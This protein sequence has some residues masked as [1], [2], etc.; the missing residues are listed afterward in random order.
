MPA[1]APAAP[2]KPAMGVQPVIPPDQPVYSL[3]GRLQAQAAALSESHSHPL[4]A[5]P[6]V[7]AVTAAPP[8]ANTDATLV[9]DGR[10]ANLASA[11]AQDVFK[12]SGAQPAERAQPD[13]QRDS[14][15][16]N[17]AGGPRQTEADLHQ[18]PALLASTPREDHKATGAASNRVAEDSRH[19]SVTASGSRLAVEQQQPPRRRRQFHD[20]PAPSGLAPGRKRS[21]S[22]DLELGRGTKRSRHAWHPTPAAHARHAEHRIP[23]QGAP[24]YDA[25]RG[26]TTLSAKQDTDREMAWSHRSSHS[27]SPTP[28]SV[29]RESGPFTAR[30][31]SMAAANGRHVAAGSRSMSISPA[32]A[33]S[34]NSVPRQPHGAA[35]GGP[36]AR[37][38]DP[39]MLHRSRDNAQHPRVAQPPGFNRQQDHR[40][41]SW[42]H[43]EYREGSLPQRESNHHRNRDR[44]FDGHSN[45]TDRAA[46]GRS[47]SSFANMCH[48]SFQSPT[49][50]Q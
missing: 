23:S 2:L 37:N 25:H 45:G 46:R 13:T 27:Q 10:A 15:R 18:R 3:D 28:R 50:P 48:T 9:V 36:H 6:V 40:K 41:A 14:Q 29:G 12:H 30:D 5:I 11:H 32:H 42:S 24:R 31:G 35:A 38:R 4:Q 39:E 16:G 21:Q 34:R 26:H 8:T 20:E 43:K 49:T 7:N 1:T 33:N 47:Q 17:G 22:P 19:S 44:E